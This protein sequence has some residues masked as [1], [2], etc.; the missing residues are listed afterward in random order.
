MSI[1]YF[2]TNRDCENLGQD[3]DREKRIKL[4]K[5]GYHF[6]DMEAYM[7]YYL[8]EVEAKTMPQGV[9][10][11]ESQGEVFESFLK[12]KRIGSI[13]ICVHGF[14]VHFHDAQTWYSILTD[15]LKHTK[16]LNNRVVTDPKNKQ[17]AKLLKDKGIKDG[18]LT[19]FIGFSWPSNGNVLSYLSDQGEARSSAH[20]LAN[21]IARIRGIPH[22]PSVNLICHSMGNFLACHMFKQ[23]VKEESLPYESDAEKLKAL[24]IRIG[25]DTADPK[26]RYFVD[27]YIM[28]APDVER[29]HV[30]KCVEIPGNIGKPKEKAPYVGQFYSGLEHLVGQVHNF[31]SRFDGALAISNYEKAPRKALVSAKG[32]LDKLTFGMIDFLERNPDEKWEQRLGAT[33]HPIIASPNMKS[34]NAVELS[35]REI[36]HSDYVDSREIVEEIANILVSPLE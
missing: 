26:K 30:T 29:R 2:A 35:G 12:N 19:A 1:R 15:T 27:R 33:Q 21:L 31:Y 11:K 8:S 6:V 36:G 5:G 24:K 7:S 14:S 13:I 20:V 32:M 25:R 23:L 3:F 4:Q 10:V 28:L 9:I 22:N 34:H 17:D 16:R 18:S